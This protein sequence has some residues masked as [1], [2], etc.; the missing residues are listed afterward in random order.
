MA[1]Y[2][3]GSGSLYGTPTRD[4]AGNPVMNG[5]TQK[6]GVLQDVSV[7]FGYDVKMLHGQLQFPVDVARGKASIKCKAKFGKLNGALYNSLF[8]GQILVSGTAT[9]IF[10]DI[11][12]SMI[13]AVAPYTITLEAPNSGTI[14]ED[15]S[16]IG[17]DGTPYEKVD[18]LPAAGQY[19]FAAG[20]FVFA[21]ADAGKKV[22]IDYK[23]TY[24]APGTK[25]ITVLNQQMG[26]TPEFRVELSQKFK[27]KPL[28]FTFPKAVSSKLMFPGKNDDYNIPEFEFEVFADDSGNVAFI[29][30]GE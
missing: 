2:S 17:A 7:D 20:V 4:S 26:Y 28:T 1:Q 21:A 15:L 19:T 16:V 12:G 18:T 3:F 9:D 22:F 6:F 11:A 23:Y 29:S 25:T 14:T 10:T 5:A 27:G 24:S 13:P 30:L 8:F